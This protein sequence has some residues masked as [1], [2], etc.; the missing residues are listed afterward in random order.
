VKPS[1]K[2]YS[3]SEYLKKE[4]FPEPETLTVCEVREEEVTAPGK[5][6]KLKVI[7]YF[8]ERQKGLVLNLANGAVL[9]LMTG[10]ADPTKWIGTR[11][12]VYHDPSVTFGGQQ[13][14]GIRLAPVRN[15]SPPKAGEP[16][17]RPIIP[18]EPVLRS[19]LD[20]NDDAREARRQ[21]RREAQAQQ[22]QRM[23]ELERE[24]E[25]AKRKIAAGK[26]DPAETDTDGNGIP[27]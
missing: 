3:D 17:R 6:P 22:V 1:Y 25:A 9:E 4:D 26:I 18:A 15:P 13:V 23:Q 10:T 5:E 24:L 12:R 16:I 19:S 27:Y 2:A 20:D 14:G 8:E 11:V 21:A 7:L